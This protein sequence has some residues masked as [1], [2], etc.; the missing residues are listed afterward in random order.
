MRK[1]NMSF[2]VDFSDSDFRRI[3]QETAG[4]DIADRWTSELIQSGFTAISNV[5]LESYSSLRPRITHGE[6]MFIVHLMQ[7]KWDKAAPF[8]SVGTISKR[9]G[10]SETAA[11]SLA[12]SLEKKGYLHRQVQ[13]GRSNRY[14]LKGLF[15]ALETYLKGD[16]PA[17]TDKSQSGPSY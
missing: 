15:T 3:E 17:D 13:P 4:R 7:H 11:R 8:P 12:R 6:A 10:I 5:F 2:P 9:M 14:H 16:S 1:S